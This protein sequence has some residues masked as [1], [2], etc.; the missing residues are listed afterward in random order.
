MKPVLIMNK[1]TGSSV[2]CWYIYTITQLIWPNIKFIGEKSELSLSSLLIRPFD[3]P[4]KVKESVFNL[5]VHINVINTSA[6]NAFD[7][8]RVDSLSSEF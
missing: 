7:H 4:L 2:S 3:N 6:R 1:Q 8:N 5:P